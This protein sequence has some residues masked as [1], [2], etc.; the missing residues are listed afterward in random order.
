MNQTKTF[1]LSK[2]APNLAF[3]LF[4]SEIPSWESSQRNKPK[5]GRIKRYGKAKGPSEKEEKGDCETESVS[6]AVWDSGRERT[7]CTW[8]RAVA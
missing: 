5:P 3:L 7:G 8:V 2:N 1:G 6:V 4:G